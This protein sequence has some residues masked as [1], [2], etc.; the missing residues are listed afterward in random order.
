MLI[1]FVFSVFQSELGRPL[2]RCTTLPPD[3]FTY[4]K[5]NEGKD[6]GAADGKFF[7]ILLGGLIF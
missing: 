1:Q 6:S 5:A 7:H 2:R 4:G 3:G